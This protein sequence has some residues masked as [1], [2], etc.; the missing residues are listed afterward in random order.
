MNKAR[1]I[2]VVLISIL[3]ISSCVLVLLSGFE[4][5]LKNNDRDDYY[6]PLY[7]T[8][9]YGNNLLQD[10]EDY[11]FNKSP[12][13]DF[14]I[15][16]F[17]PYYLFSLPWQEK[18]TI[19]TKSPIV[20][21]SNDGFREI[22]IQPSS[23]KQL[24]FLGGSTAFSHFSSKNTT[25]IGAYLSQLSPLRVVNRNAPSWNSHQESI[26]LFKYE[27]LDKVEASVSF[28]LV[29]DIVVSCQGNLNNN[30]A[31][32]FPENWTKLNNLVSSTQGKNKTKASNNIINFEFD[33][34][35]KV[36]KFAQ[37]L[38]PNIY[39][40]LHEIK[41][42]NTFKKMEEVA[43]KKMTAKPKYDNCDF[44]HIENVAESFLLNQ[45]RMSNIA[46]AYG[47]KHFVILQPHLDLHK[48]ASI[49][50]DQT[51]GLVNE[52]NRL[53]KFKKAVIKNV[54]D[55]EFCSKNPCLDLSTV[56]D[57]KGYFLKQYNPSVANN[58]SYLQKWLKSGV[59]VDN[60]HLN[61]RG[62][63]VVAKEIAKWI[64]SFK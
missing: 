59:F 30:E 10:D 21:I 27:S 35:I 58:S 46:K 57:N 13:S 28:S 63:K 25:T 6:L 15:Q 19:K 5:V 49:D 22:E 20:S 26:A 53:I 36:K 61:D 50:E 54:L 7:E 52:K 2:G 60:Y 62:N 51:A 47:F 9:Y 12:Y 24:I 40:Y 17:H 48:D 11:S 4:L 42:K 64:S 18:D 34:V 32:D 45:I 31:L 37:R 38:F 44:I 41:K 43:I 33:I 1:F 23:D 16:Y 29:N 39:L 8:E 14:T 3:I 55:S 56:F